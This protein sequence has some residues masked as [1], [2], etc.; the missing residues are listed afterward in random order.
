MKWK[1][2][3]SGLGQQVLLLAVNELLVRSHPPIV[4]ARS[5]L[6][7]DSEESKPST[8]SEQP[9]QQFRDR[10]IPLP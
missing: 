6:I 10:T 2:F 5:Q 9:P 3:F 1:S 8:I 7:F 4:P